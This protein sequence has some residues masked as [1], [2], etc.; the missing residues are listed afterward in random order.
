MSGRKS[1][2]NDRS[3]SRPTL[4]A[5]EA[6]ARRPL[7]GD[8]ERFAP[9]VVL[10][11]R[12][13]LA[14]HL[15]RGGM[16]VVWSATDLETGLEVAIKALVAEAYTAENLR[17]FR[18]EAQSAAALE[19][20]YV[21]AVH[22]LGVFGGAPFI[23]MERLRGEPL[24]QRLDETG[25]LPA[26]EAVSIML[27]LLEGLAAAHD[28]GVL[29]RDVKP[30]NV[31]ITTPRGTTTSIK[32]I[33]FGLARRLRRVTDTDEVTNITKLNTIP[34]TPAYLAP[35][36]FAAVRDLDQ[37]VDVWAAGATFYEMLVGRPAFAGPEFP[38][39]ASRI[40]REPFEPACSIRPEL[41]PGLDRVLAVALAKDR[42]ERYPSAAAFRDA[43]LS[44]W[45]RHRT[46]GV[47]RGEKL[48][49]YAGKAG[50]PARASARP[51][52]A[53]DEVGAEDFTELDV[54]I[55]FDPE[56]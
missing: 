11:G 8:E 41:P 16:G 22:H 42:R 29:H 53:V 55:Q 38:V 20:R 19:N 15:G 9:G 46:E 50:P 13:R 14:S 48:R 21:C 26:S 52:R 51:R 23:V 3:A 4:G 47:A 30:A 34:G 45:A 10:A 54:H 6:S 33:D 28:A 36:Q 18:R 5:G 24:A 44:E 32:I 7:V 2:A 27:Q 12:Y 37:R 39:L 25:A 43:L 40:L 31:F 35:E 17:R 1:G 56:D 49:A